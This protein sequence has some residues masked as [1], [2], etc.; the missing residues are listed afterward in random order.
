MTRHLVPPRDGVEGNEIKRSARGYKLTYSGVVIM[1]SKKIREALVQVS[2]RSERVM[3]V[4][5]SEGNTNLTV[6]S[7]YASQVECEDVEKD[8]FWKE[9]DQEINF[10]SKNEN[11]IIGGDLNEHVGQDLERVE[12]WHGGWSVGERNPE[13]RRFWIS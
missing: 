13:G 10:V 3:S 11:T 7:A 6:V 2:R 8:K 1:L 5:L 12:R 9:L 4:K